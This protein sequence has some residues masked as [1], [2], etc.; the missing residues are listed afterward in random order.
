MPNLV[1]ESSLGTITVADFR[2]PV[3]FFSTPVSNEAFDAHPL[4]FRGLA[5]DGVFRVENSSLIRRLLAI[6]HAPGAF[7][8]MKHYIF[9]FHDSIF[10]VA[11]EGL[12]LRTVEGSMQDAENEML[13]SLR[14]SPV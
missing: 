8:E 4:A 14:K 1:S 13:Q 5:G 10:E 6:R 3:A 12:E 11:A 7:S 2:R 9:V